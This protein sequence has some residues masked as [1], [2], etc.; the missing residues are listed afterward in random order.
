MCV[1]L[2]NPSEYISHVCLLKHS[3]SMSYQCTTIESFEK[4]YAKNSHQLTCSFLSP[5][6][7]FDNSLQNQLSVKIKLI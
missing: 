6:F 2:L 7:F 5:F 1:V 3:N 4:C